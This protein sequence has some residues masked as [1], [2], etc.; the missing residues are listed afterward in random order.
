MKT[1]LS[2]GLQNLSFGMPMLKNSY[3]MRNEE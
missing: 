2:I 1:E 3:E